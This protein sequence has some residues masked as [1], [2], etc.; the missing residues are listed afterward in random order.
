[1]N[2]KEFKS[3]SIIEDQ[4]A[5]DSFFSCVNYFH[6]SLLKEVTILSRGYVNKDLFMHGDCAPQDIRLIVQMQSKETPCVEMLFKDIKTFNIES[7]FSL[8]PNGKIEDGLITIYFAEEEYKDLFKIVAK[9][10]K[11]RILGEEYL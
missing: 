6:D 5:L 7:G 1:M 11:Y 4:R 3:Y 9:S 2:N 10:M 8:E